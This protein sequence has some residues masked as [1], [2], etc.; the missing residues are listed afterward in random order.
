MP[1]RVG[2]SHSA[3][4]ED[5][6][7]LQMRAGEP[8]PDHGAVLYARGDEYPR[9]GIEDQRL[10]ADGELYFGAQVFGVFVVAADMEDNLVAAFAVGVLKDVGVGVGHIPYPAEFDIG[11]AAGDEVVAH[12]GHGGVLPALD[13]AGGHF[14]AGFSDQV[15]L[16]IGGHC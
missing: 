6:R 12:Q 13:V 1:A 11:V 14:V 9:G 7:N 8:F 4:A 15:F 10:A 5:H 16:P 3:R 2:L